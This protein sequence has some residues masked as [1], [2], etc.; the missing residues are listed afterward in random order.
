MHDFC[1]KLNDLVKYN[2]KAKSLVFHLVGQRD[3]RVP[4]ELQKK[5]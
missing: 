3:R 4:D 2:R 5:P 1:I